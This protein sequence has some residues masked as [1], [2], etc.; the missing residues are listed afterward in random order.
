MLQSI[1]E[2][3]SLTKTQSVQLGSIVEKKSLGAVLALVKE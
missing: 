2:S 1:W 3:R